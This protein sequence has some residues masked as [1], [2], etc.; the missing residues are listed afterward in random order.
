LL[1]LGF[2]ESVNAPKILDDFGVTVRKITM[3]VPAVKGRRPQP[4][5]TFVRHPNFPIPRGSRINDFKEA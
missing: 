2:E 1:R 5:D 4:N 3:I